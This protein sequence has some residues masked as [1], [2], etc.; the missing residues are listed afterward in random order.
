MSSISLL[1]FFVRIF[2]FNQFPCLLFIADSQLRKEFENDCYFSLC[3]ILII[4]SREIN[5]LLSCSHMSNSTRCILESGWRVNSCCYTHD[6]ECLH[7]AKAQRRN[8][9]DNNVCSSY[10]VPFLIQATSKC[11]TYYFWQICTPT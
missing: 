1:T 8:T 11:F 10:L 4:K 3:V 5:I 7:D 2:Y 6:M 9:S